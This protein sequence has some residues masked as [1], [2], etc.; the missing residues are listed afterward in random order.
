M[1][2]ECVPPVGYPGVMSALRL[3]AI[4]CASL[5]AAAVTPLYAQTPSLGAAKAF[6]AG[7]YTG[8]R[9]GEP[10]YLG[11]D[12]RKAFAPALLDLIAQD[13]RTTPSGDVGALDG[14]PICD[15]QDPGGLKL[16][17]LTVT[18]AGAGQARAEVAFSLDGDRRRLKIDLVASGAGWRIADIH[19]AD[20]PS[21]VQLLQRE[22][23]H[24]Q[25]GRRRR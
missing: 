25:H 23:S 14:D 11:R 24:R 9:T 8:Y 1:R 13:Q 5:C 7:L 21:L 10:D 3:I 16:T 4:I 19:S 17:Q 15:C 12:A 22:L 6:V 18:E 2:M 20:T